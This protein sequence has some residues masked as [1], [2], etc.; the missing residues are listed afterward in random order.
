M[1]IQG[2]NKKG[3]KGNLIKKLKDF[4][5]SLKL[6]I[7][8]MIILALTSIVGTIIPQNASPDQYLRYYS[9]TTYQ[10]L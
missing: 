10:T 8:L 9:L 5:T 6:T 7:L 2:N 3:K 4:L 1:G